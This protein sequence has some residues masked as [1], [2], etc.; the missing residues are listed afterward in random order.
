VLAPP[1]P[2]GRSYS[3]FVLSGVLLR[4]GRH[5]EAARYAASA[6]DTARAPML[7]VHVARA[8]AALGQRT[9]ALAWLRTASGT[10]PDLVAHAIETAPE[11]DS[12]R[13]DPEFAAAITP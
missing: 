5:E 1:I 10:T 6:Y 9:T 4:V 12:L 11:F 13:H 2:Q 3:A 7:A 8:A